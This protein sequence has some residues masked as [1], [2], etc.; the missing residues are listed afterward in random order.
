MSKVPNEM[1]TLCSNVSYLTSGINNMLCE[2]DNGGS[3][4]LQNLVVLLVVALNIWLKN[5]RLDYE[6]VQRRGLF[7]S[8]TACQKQT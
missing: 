6:E 5:V 8:K 1:S 4:M 3:A 2:M 7:D